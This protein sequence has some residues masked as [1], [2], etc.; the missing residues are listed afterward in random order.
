MACRS[1]AGFL[2][3]VAFAAACGG[4]EQ[5]EGVAASVNGETISIAEVEAEIA[6]MPQAMQERSR[7]PEGSR[8]LVEQLVDQRLLLQEARTREL[9]EDPELRAKVA[10]LERRLLVDAVQQRV[11]RDVVTDEAVRAYY[12]AHPDEFSEERVR[13]R[14]I[15]VPEKDA[16]Q[17]I[18]DELRAGADFLTVARERSQD[19]SARRG[20]DLGY[21]T[22][23]RMDPAFEKAAFELAQPGALSEVVQTRFGFHV[24]QLVEKPE[25][26]I[27]PF[28]Q[29]KGPIRQKLQR[30]AIEG[31]L[32]ERRASSKIEIVTKEGA[33]P[34]P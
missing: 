18:L 1:S 34:A 14:H 4:S 22:R 12:D 27:R 30:E 28:D 20:G 19:P 15:L 8:R 10:D 32:E 13:V 3:L 33:E 7:T 5:G 23:G 11:T 24:I 9:D 25:S 16:A 17:K 31:F 26:Q 6:R 29:A 21:V 2:L